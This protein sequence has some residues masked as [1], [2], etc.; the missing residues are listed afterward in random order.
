MRSQALKHIDYMILRSLK[1][2]T[3]LRFDLTTPSQSDAG[4][5]H[6]LQHKHVRVSLY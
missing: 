2:H 1:V 3:S 5:I 6:E 4:S